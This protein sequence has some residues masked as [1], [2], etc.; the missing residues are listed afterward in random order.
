MTNLFL[1]WK[2]RTRNN[3]TMKETTQYWKLHY[4]NFYT[5]VKEDVT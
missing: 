3:T 4:T 2:K 1:L 5:D